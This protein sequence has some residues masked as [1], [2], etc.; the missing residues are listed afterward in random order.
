M[1]YFDILWAVD[2]LGTTQS[3]EGVKGIKCVIKVAG[4][5]DTTVVHVDRTGYGEGVSAGD[6]KHFVPSKI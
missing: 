6:G 2:R 3:P 4:G 1:S 5:E